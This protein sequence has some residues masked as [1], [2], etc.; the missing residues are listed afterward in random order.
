[1]NGQ[2]Q[3]LL[4]ALLIALMLH[5]ILLSLQLDED[6]VMPAAKALQW[7]PVSLGTRSVVKK[8][9]PQKQQLP[10]SEEKKAVA[11]S[12]RP[13]A[14]EDREPPVPATTTIPLHIQKPTHRKTVSRQRPVQSKPQTAVATPAE[15]KKIPLAA[16]VQERVPSSSSREEEESSDPQASLAAAVLQQAIP[17][18]RINPPPEYPRLARRRGLEGVV[19]LEVLVN[20]SGRVA[21]I[22]ISSSSGYALLDKAALKGVRRWHFTPGTMNGRQ[23]EM[24]VEIPVRFQLR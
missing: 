1:M 22:R 5:G 7:I 2:T 19:L 4:P 10:P 20:S 9:R 6:R 16:P 17:L 21:D 8:P 24:W 18:Y 13:I 15:Q 11:P 12:V 23:Q 14:G 3:R